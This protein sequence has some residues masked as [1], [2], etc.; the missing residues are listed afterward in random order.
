MRLP[1]TLSLPFRHRRLVSLV[2]SHVRAETWTGTVLVSRRGRTLLRVARGAADRARGIVNEPETRF[3][4]GSIGKTFTALAA[5]RL[6]EAGRLSL[7]DP[8]RRFAPEWIDSDAI[9]IRHLLSNTSGIPDFLTLP[10]L[11]PRI[12]EPHALAD[13]LAYLRGLPP[14]FPPGERLSYSNTNWTLLALAIERITGD[15]FD[16]ALRALVL[17]PLDLVS[18]APDSGATAPGDAIGYT[19]GESS[20]EPA[21]RIHPSVERGAGGLRSTV[22]DLLRLDAAIAKPG[23]LSASSL[24]RMRRTVASDGPIG[25]G[26]GLFSTTR[27]G[28]TTIGHSGGTFGFTAFWSR[29][30][31]DDVVTIVLANV[32]NGSADRLER[33]LAAVAFG[34]RVDPITARTFVTVSADVLAR[35]AGRYQSSFAGRRIDFAVELADD[36]LFAAFPLLPRVPL[37]PLSSTRFFTRLKGGDVTFEFVG[38]AGAITGIRVDWSGTAMECPRLA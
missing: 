37:R 10:A 7:D 17:G 29:Y 9:L 6:I 2:D 36:R 23:L 20:W 35:Y 26:L 22:D 1:L 32:D 38:A 31:A 14:L 4:I 16:T 25:Y 8:A 11:Q 19:I 13:V 18:T 30:P 5:M 24:D 21:A 27:S 34:D 33:D 3:R 15:S 12:A 28:R